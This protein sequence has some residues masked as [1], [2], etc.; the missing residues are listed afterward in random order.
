MVDRGLCGCL[1]W[2]NHV[3]VH[4]VNWHFPTTDRFDPVTDDDAALK[5]AL[6]R[7]GYLDCYHMSTMWEQCD[8]DGQ[9]WRAALEAKYEGKGKAFTRKDWDLLLGHCQAV[10]DQ[11]CAAFAEEL[12]STYPHAKVVLTTRSSMQQWVASAQRLE[13]LHVSYAPPRWLAFLHKLLLPIKIGSSDAALALGIVHRHADNSR[14]PESSYTGHNDRIR[15]LCA[16]EGR[17]LLEFNVKDGWAPLCNYLGHEIPDEPF[18]HT[19]SAIQEEQELAQAVYERN[20]LVLRNS[21]ACLG[22]MLVL[23]LGV[24]RAWF[25]CRK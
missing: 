11:P 10:T 9:S 19:H 17:P 2:G 12:L 20:V 23:A 14:D 18:P 4:I 3:L 25:F 13:A 21:T 7:L 15:T 5:A 1:P 16:Q 8:R 6:E 24:Y 22:T